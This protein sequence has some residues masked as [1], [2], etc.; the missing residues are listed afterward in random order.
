MSFKEGMPEPGALGIGA[1][2]WT[3]M[4]DNAGLQ[5]SYRSHRS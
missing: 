3:E 4:L 1:A 2:F 5:V